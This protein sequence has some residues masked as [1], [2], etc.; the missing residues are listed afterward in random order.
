MLARGEVARRG[1]DGGRQGLLGF[2]GGAQE[3]RVHQGPRDVARGDVDFGALDHFSRACPQRH[4]PP[5][6]SKL[7]MGLVDLGLRRGVHGGAPGKGWTAECTPR[8][9]HGNAG[10]LNPSIS[11][12]RAATPR[13][14]GRAFSSSARNSSRSA[15]PAGV[16]ARAISR[17]VSRL[18]CSAWGL[19]RSSSAA[20][21]T[22]VAKRRSTLAALN[23]PASALATK[24]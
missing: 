1:G 10:P 15:L 6:A 9:P 8:A 24:G 12:Q 17:T 5:R 2:R 3:G 18:Q 13:I 20:P 16:A 22:A 7:R 11:V 23:V 19:P 21:I 4:P 14:S